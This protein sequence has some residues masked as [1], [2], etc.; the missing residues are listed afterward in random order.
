MPAI[1]IVDENG[2]RTASLQEILANIQER[3]RAALGEDLAM[4]PETPQGQIAGIDSTALREVNEGIT[5]I[6]QQLSVDHAGGIYLDF[7][8]GLLD[9]RRHASTYSRVTAT[10]T[11][12][13]GTGVPAGSRAR[14]DP[15]TD[16]FTTL[17]D[18]VLS[19]SG[20]TVDMQAV[21]PGPVEAPAG[22]LTKIVTIIPGWETVTNGSAAALGITEQA[23][24]EY[25]ADYILRTA[26]SSIG[27]TP[28][29]R[30]A[31]AEAMAIRSTVYGKQHR[32]RDNGAG[33]ADCAKQHAWPL[34]S[35]ALITTY[36]VP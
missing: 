30:G 9:I 5:Q 20:V 12:V 35:R 22:T 31:L 3:Y 25:R 28:A 33:M 29:M 1:I 7:L 36:A 14:T 21:K 16:E 18:V 13:A 32:H 11:G 19:P 17:S 27:P 4:Q 15:G 26:H 23:D 2:I 6:A 8:G 10:L 24:Q 34:S